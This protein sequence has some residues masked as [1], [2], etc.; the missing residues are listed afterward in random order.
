MRVPTFVEHKVRARI[1][2]II[3]ERKNIQSVNNFFLLINNY[4]SK[5]DRIQEAIASNDWTKCDNVATQVF[6]PLDT[7]L[8]CISSGSFMCFLRIL[9]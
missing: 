9:S 6:F 7:T 5:P 4:K 8:I 3:P 1:T 2:S